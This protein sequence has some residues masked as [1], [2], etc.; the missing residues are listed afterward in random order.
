M[1]EAVNASG[2]DALLVALGCPK[3]DLWIEAH[4]RE[5]QVSL[6][7]GVGCV[8][9]VIAGA[10]R[11]APS[12]LQ[13]VGLEWLYRLAQEPQ[14]LGGRYLADAAFVCRL[15]YRCARS[16]LQSRGMDR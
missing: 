12:L 15:M 6:A 10:S 7:M 14:R 8:L 3:Q 9:D 2:A 5:L 1:V 13:A 4:K 16:R 11:R